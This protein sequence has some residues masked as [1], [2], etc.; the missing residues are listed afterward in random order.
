MFILRHAWYTNQAPAGSGS[1]VRPTVHGGETTAIRAHADSPVVPRVSMDYIGLAGIERG[2]RVLRTDF[3]I[4]PVYHHRPPR[5]VLA[6][7]LACFVA[8]TLFDVMRTPHKASEREGGTH[9]DSPR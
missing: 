1:T 7:A 2:L 6:H 3:E 9:A 5:R 4:G 8:P